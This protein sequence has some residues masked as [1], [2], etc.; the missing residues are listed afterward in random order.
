MLILSTDSIE[1]SSKEVNNQLGPIEV[2]GVVLLVL[3]A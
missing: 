1:P 3:W 2:E